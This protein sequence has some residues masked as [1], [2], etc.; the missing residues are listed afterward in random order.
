MVKSQKKSLRVGKFVDTEHVDTVIRTYKHERWKYNSERI[1]KEDS[2]SSWYSIEEL[3]NFISTCKKH[4]GDGVRIYFGAYPEDFQANPQYAGRQ[5]L[6]FVGTKRKETER[7]E[8]DKDIYLQSEN[9]S[10]I[11]AYNIGKICP[12]NCGGTKD[13]DGGG[14]IGITIIDRKEK[15]MTIV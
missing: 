15:G 10:R 1:G 7:G 12:P 2:L 9:R 11:L 13:P 5:T 6:V 8:I 14:E 3:E 4:G